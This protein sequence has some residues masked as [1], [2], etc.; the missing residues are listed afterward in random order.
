MIT[1]DDIRKAVAFW[2]VTVYPKYWAGKNP[3][4]IIQ[5]CQT[6]GSAELWFADQPYESEQAAIDAAYTMILTL[7]EK[8]MNLLKDTNLFKYLTGDMF[9]KPAVLTIQKVQ[10]EEMPSGSTTEQKPVV[11]FKETRKGLVLNKTNANALYTL[12]GTWDTEVMRGKKV[13]LFSERGQAFGKPY[14]AVRISTDLPRESR[15]QATL[16]PDQP[17]LVPADKAV[18][19]GAYDE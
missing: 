7:G 13:R 4:Y 12:F 19:T 17:E 14:N 6:I 18:A 11:Y 1:L 9:E 2:D 5:Y 8:Y 15:P 3:R 16:A 10:M